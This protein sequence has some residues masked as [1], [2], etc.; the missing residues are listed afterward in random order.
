VS[1][2]TRFEDWG[3]ISYLAF[4]TVLNLVFVSFTKDCSSSDD[5]VVHNYG[6]PPAYK[7]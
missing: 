4:Y 3:A 2:W 5:G 6:A 7:A 1:D